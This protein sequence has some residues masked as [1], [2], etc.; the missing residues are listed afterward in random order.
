MAKYQIWNRKDTVITPSGEVFTPEQWVAKHP[1]C[2]VESIKTVISGDVIN[3]ALLY[4]FSGFVKRMEKAGCDFSACTTDEEYLDAIE[5]FEEAQAQA[6]AAAAQEATTDERIV[7]A[8]EAQV[9]MSLPDEDT[10]EVA[11]ETV[12]EN[13]VE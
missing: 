12:S 9:M 6:A 10:E 4:E 11:D 13:S 3:G 8:L 5:V 2:G 1:I 7:A